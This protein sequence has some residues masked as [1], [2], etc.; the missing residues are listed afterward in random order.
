M[1][2]GMIYVGDLAVVC[3]GEGAA[4]EDMGRGKAGGFG[5]TVEE[6]Y[7]VRWG[8]EQDARISAYQR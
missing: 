8:D 7:L 3:F 6:Q 4:G 5:H 2:T 1:S